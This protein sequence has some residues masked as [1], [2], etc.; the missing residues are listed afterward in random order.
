MENKNETYEEGRT[1]YIWVKDKKG[2]EYLC[3]SNVLIDKKDVTEEQLKY[4]VDDLNASVNP[5]G[6]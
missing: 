3:P 1:N 6:G 4:C 2:E 5:R